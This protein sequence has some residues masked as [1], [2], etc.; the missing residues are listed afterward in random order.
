MNKTNCTVFFND[1]S[2]KLRK[3]TS[4]YK[5]HFVPL[6]LGACSCSVC[7]NKNLSQNIEEEFIPL[8]KTSQELVHDEGVKSLNSS[9]I[10]RLLLVKEKY[11]KNSAIRIPETILFKNG[12]PEI[13][14]KFHE[15]SQTMQ[16]STKKTLLQLNELLK[17]FI[18]KIGKE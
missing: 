2:F 14:I 9:D 18:K 17:I 1:N 3:F 6:S 15:E 5:R 8:L 11:Q 4:L 7:T 16:F 10:F 12:L 13:I